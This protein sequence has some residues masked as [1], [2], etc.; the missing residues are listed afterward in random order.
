MGV[1]LLGG[2]PGSTPPKESVPVMKGYKC[3][4]IRPKSMEKPQSKNPTPNYF[5]SYVPGSEKAER[6]L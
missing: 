6:M 2:V 4:K 5:S 3:I 1:Y